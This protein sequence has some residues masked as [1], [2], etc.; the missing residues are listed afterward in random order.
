[1]DVCFRD[2][3]PFTYMKANVWNIPLAVHSKVFLCLKKS[4][5]LEAKQFQ[6]RIS[7]VS[8]GKMTEVK[9]QININVK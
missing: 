3:N 6:N 1:M 9:Q 4:S 5:K 2:G 7:N 8:F